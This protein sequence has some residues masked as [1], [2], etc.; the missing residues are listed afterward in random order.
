MEDARPAESRSTAH[1]R[2]QRPGFR[3]GIGAGAA[4]AKLIVA[5]FFSV[6]LVLSIVNR[7]NVFFL[8]AIGIIWAIV[9]AGLIVVPIIASFIADSLSQHGGRQAFSPPDQGYDFDSWVQEAMPPTY[10]PLPEPGMPWRGPMA[11]P[12]AVGMASGFDWEGLVQGVATRLET[13]LG[14]G[15]AAE[16]EGAALVLRYGPMVRKVNLRSIFQPPPMEVSERALR[17]CLKMMDEAQM[18]SMRVRQAPWPNREGAV[19]GAPGNLPR[20]RVRL[21]EGEIRMVWADSSGTVLRL[22]PLPFH[23]AVGSGR[24]VTW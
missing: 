19:I 9:F 3:L 15:Y 13:A 17:G 14:E 7:W 16:A 11:R 1:R 23:G 18:F 21:D 20:P 5:I 22:R 6:L 8:I 10:P 24:D 12:L 2:A 4:L